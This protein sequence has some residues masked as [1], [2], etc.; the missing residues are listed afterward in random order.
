MSQAVPVIGS[1]TGGIREVVEPD[2]TGRI[3]PPGDVAALAEAMVWA[4]G[5]RPRLRALG[6]R[7]L[8]AVRGRTHRAMHQDRAA[9]IREALDR[10][11]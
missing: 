10:R 2:Q 11:P 6:L 1:D 9:I 7:G 5:N 4:A 3:V 8:E